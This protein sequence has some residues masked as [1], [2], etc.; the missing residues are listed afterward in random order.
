[1]KKIF[2]HICN[3]EL[4]ELMVHPAFI[5]HYLMEN[6]SFNIGRLY[7]HK[8]LTSDYI[9]TLVKE[10]NIELATYSDFIKELK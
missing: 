5:D 10:N 2:D 9:K 8:N 6:S 1:M 7:E 3:Y 4:V